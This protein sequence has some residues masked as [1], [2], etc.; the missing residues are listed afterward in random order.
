M[1][2]PAFLPSRLVPPAIAP[3][4]SPGPAG[5]TGPLWALV[6]CNNFYASCERL[7]RPDL[8]GKPIVV[9]SNN[10]GCIISRSDEAKALGVEM[11]APEF[12]VRRE[13]ARLGVHVFSSNYALYGDLSNRVMRTLGTLAPEVEVYSIDE[14]FLPLR[15]PLATDPVG[16]GRA[17]RERVG[18]WT[19]IP[20]SVGIAPTRTLAK[21]AGRVAK[22]TPRCEGMFDLAH[23]REVLGMGVDDFLGKVPVDAVWGVGRR[24]AAMLR[25]AGITTARALRDAGDDWVRRR[26]SV[27]GLRTVLELRGLPCIGA[28]EQGEPPAPRHTV[29]S[30][31]SFAGRITDV[32]MLREAL[33]THAALA[34]AKL[35]RAGLVAG[36]LAV[37]V[38]TARHDE[39]AAL[40]CDD[41][42][43]L[44]L[45]VPTAD[46]T[47]FIRLAHEG[48]D[49][50]FRPGYPYAKAG[51]MLYGLEPA[52]TRQGSLLALVDGTAER[53]AARERLM[54]VADR[55]NARH[56]RGTLRHAA[57]GLAKEA[58][59][60]MRQRRRSPRRTTA[61]KELAQALCK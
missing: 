36:G 39:E 17:L 2:V 33:A 34:G 18:R 32:A 23:C 15:G 28:A 19:G 38:R 43:S 21:L 30:S 9:L 6:D 27:T 22:R 16:V 50:V 55:V 59:W 26:M 3:S 53:D 1:P 14:A 56:G 42:V 20:I 40:R 35:R 48:L 4:P 47:T 37:H 29:V 41:G 57:E 8:R 44:P 5:P 24:L 25:G 13:L 31:R 10:D 46:T 12:K 61:W 52:D 58:P 11:G 60:H 54:A 45:P 49:R 7:F 51:V